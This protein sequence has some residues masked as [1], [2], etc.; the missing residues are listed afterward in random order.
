MSKIGAGEEG[1]EGGRSWQRPQCER[2]PGAAGVSGCGVRPGRAALVWRWWRLSQ[3]S[4]P[5][6]LPGT[7]LSFHTS[8]GKTRGRPLPGSHPGEGA[9]SGFLGTDR[10]CRNLSEN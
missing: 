6:P 7:L 10:G 8:C 1:A 3:G 5:S 9:G 4:T 2:R